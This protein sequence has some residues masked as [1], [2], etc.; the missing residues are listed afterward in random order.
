MN[1][2]TYNL[3]RLFSILLV[4]VF[5]LLGMF[6]P[7]SLEIFFG[8]SL[9]GIAGILIALFF[10]FKEERLYRNIVYGLLCL[11]SIVLIIVLL[12]SKNLYFYYP[13]QII[14]MLIVAFYV[15]DTLIYIN[16][17]KP[18][19]RVIKNI[20]LGIMSGV[21]AIIG[22]GSFISH[23]AYQRSAFSSMAEIFLQASNSGAFDSEESA[24]SYMSKRSELNDLEYVVPNGSYLSSISIKTLYN[25]Q[26]VYFENNS[27][28]KGYIL[29]IHGGAYV[30]QMSS[31]HVSFCDK[32]AK[33]SGYTVIAPI[34]PLAPVHVYQ[35]TYDL[36]ETIYQD[37]LLTNKDI[38][39]AGDSAGGGFVASFVEYLNDKNTIA[40]SKIILLSPWV[41]VSMSDETYNNYYDPMLGVPG[42][43]T[44]G[45]A[46]ADDLSTQ[47]YHISP[48]FGDVSNFSRILIFVGTREIFYP[49]VN[50]FYDKLV[51]ANIDA[52]LEIGQGMNHVYPVY[53]TLE[54]RMAINKIVSFIIG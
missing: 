45:E 39:L 37:L 13:I 23:V 48:L 44:M 4:F 53:P 20:G 8:L 9:I 18:K 49:D 2:K 31:S 35:E 38:V 41:D 17:T 21:V 26:A 27:N 12:F 11:S 25:H 40:P 10:N 33:L 42:L 52:T 54:A 16:L 3:L 6:L 15:L 50:K 7:F 34:Y 36:I 43:I 1:N 46:W 28:P 32:V 51:T 22:V 30:N 29:Y 47:D 5:S 14:N 19:K 24:R